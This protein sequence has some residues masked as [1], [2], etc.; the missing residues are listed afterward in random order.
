MVPRPE[1]V[2][3]NPQT[4]RPGQSVRPRSIPGGDRNGDCAAYTC[5]LDWS[6][7]WKMMSARTFRRLRR[8]AFPSSERE[9]RWRPGGRVRLVAA[10]DGEY[11]RTGVGGRRTVNFHRGTTRWLGSG[12][13][14]KG[15]PCDRSE[16]DPSSVGRKVKGHIIAPLGREAR[17]HLSPPAA[18]PPTDHPL[19]PSSSTRRASWSRVGWKSPLAARRV[20]GLSWTTSEFVRHVRSR[21]FP[22]LIVWPIRRSVIK[23]RWKNKNKNH[24]NN[25]SNTNRFDLSVRKT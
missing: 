10:V 3:I 1:N 13:V 18:R 11:E 9:G 4:F 12:V 25:S 23:L 17:C 5:G 20:C 21:R 14:V 6:G 22:R 24:L 19:S 15:I 7:V 16:C 2:P 8:D